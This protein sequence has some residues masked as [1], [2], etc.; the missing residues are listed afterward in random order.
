MFEQWCPIR[1]RMG[2]PVLKVC[3]STLVEYLD[4]LQVTHSYAYMTL[5][6]HA[7]AICSILQP[8][9][10]IRVSMAPLVK[11]LLKGVF[12]RNPPSTVWAA[13]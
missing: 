12:G 2:L 8:A 3:V 10:Q 11:Q 13:T 5:C 6:M 4:F 7:S 1:H 9:E